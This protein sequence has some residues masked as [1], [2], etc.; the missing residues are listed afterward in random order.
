MDENEV[1]AIGSLV[2]RVCVKKVFCVCVCGMMMLRNKNHSYGL[3]VNE[4]K[5]K[6]S[7]FELSNQMTYTHWR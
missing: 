2:E 5:D 3:L 7:R 1:E 6:D 4:K